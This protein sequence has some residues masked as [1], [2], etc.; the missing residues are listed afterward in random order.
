[1]L[2]FA[3]PCVV[4]HRRITVIQRGRY[5]GGRHRCRTVCYMTLKHVRI[6]LCVCGRFFLNFYDP[7]QNNR[8]GRSQ[9]RI[10][11]PLQINTVLSGFTQTSMSIFE[12]AEAETNLDNLSSEARRIVEAVKRQDKE[13]GLDRKPAPL[14]HW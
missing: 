8:S 13:A 2:E 7:S 6:L 5:Q 12:D 14:R 11:E 4:D 1:M 3:R 9:V 10:P